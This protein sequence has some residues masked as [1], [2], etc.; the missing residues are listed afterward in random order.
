[1][2][3]KKKVSEPDFGFAEFRLAIDAGYHSV[4]FVVEALIRS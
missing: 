4:G 1:M 3:S 2:P